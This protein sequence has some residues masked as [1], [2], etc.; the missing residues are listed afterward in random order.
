MELGIFTDLKQKK[1]FIGRCMQ[2]N[3]DMYCEKHYSLLDF[4]LL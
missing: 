4:Y 1:V 2:K 3:N